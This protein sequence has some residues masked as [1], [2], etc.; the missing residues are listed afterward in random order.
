MG[1][2]WFTSNTKDVSMFLKRNRSCGP[3][4]RPSRF[5]FG[6]FYRNIRKRPSNVR[7]KP[8]TTPRPGILRGEVR[9]IKT[10]NRCG[11]LESVQSIQSIFNIKAKTKNLGDE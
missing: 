10:R 6:T 5:R 8:P 3:I 7:C 9:G 1:G 4:E 11:C 2:G